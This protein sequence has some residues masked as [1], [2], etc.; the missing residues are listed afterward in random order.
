[1][2]PSKS[3]NGCLLYHMVEYALM[4]S[5]LYCA[6][7]HAGII[8]QGLD[9]SDEGKHNLVYSCNVTSANFTRVTIKTMNNV[10]RNHTAPT[11]HVMGSMSILFSSSPLTTNTVT[12]LQRNK[13][14]ISATKIVSCHLQHLMKELVEQYSTILYRSYCKSIH[15]IKARMVEL[16]SSSI[17]PPCT[18]WCVLV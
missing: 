6:Q 9:R 3:P 1:M 17:V 11:V 4:P 15:R 2:W 7:N 8:H 5:V 14:K 10:C 12:I 18:C 16:E 13:R